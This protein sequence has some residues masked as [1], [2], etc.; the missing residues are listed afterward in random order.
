MTH[1]SKVHIASDTL[2]AETLQVEE[3]SQLSEYNDDN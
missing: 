3:Y 2:I 1:L